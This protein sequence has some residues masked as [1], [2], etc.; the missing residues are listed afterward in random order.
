[1]ADETDPTVST[2]SPTDNATGVATNSNLVITFSEAVDVETGN[3]TIKKTS[4]NSTVEAIDVTGG[5]VTGTG[6]DTITINPTSDLDEQIEYYVLID[7]TAFADAASNFYAGIASTT[8]WSFTTADETDPTV[9]TLSPTDNATAVATNSDLVITFSEAMY[10]GTGNI[11]LYKATGDVD[12]LVQA[13]DVE[14]E[15]DGIGTNTITINPTSDLDS[16]TDY[17]VL[18]EADA[19][20][21]ESGNSF[22]GIADTTTWNFTSADI[23]NPAVSILSPADDA[24]A[25][26]V[27]SNFIITFSEAMYVGTGNI[28]LYKATGDVDVLVQ[29]FDVTTDITGTGDTILINPTSNLDGETDYYVQIDATAFED[30]SGN[31]FAGIADTITWNFTSADIANPTISGGLPS[32][33]QNADTTNVTMSVTTN[34]N[35]TCKYSSTSGIAFALMTAFTTTD[36]TSHS[37]SISGLNNGSSY[38]YYVLCQDSS[39]NE[40]TETTISFSVAS[41]IVSGGGGGGGGFSRPYSRTSEG[42]EVE[43][44]PPLPRAPEGGYVF[45][46]TP[47]P[48][49]NGFVTL[50]FEGGQD[51]TRIHISD[52]PSFSPVTYINYVTSTTWTFQSAGEKTLYAKFCNQYA[53]CGETIIAKVMYSPPSSPSSPPSP[54]SPQE[55]TEPNFIEK[56]TP[57]FI[58]KSPPEPKLEEPVVKETPTLSL[59]GDWK[60]LPN[61]LV[62][63][64]VL[65]PLPSDITKLTDKFPELEKVFARLGITKISDLEK[66]KNTSINLPLVDNKK[67]VP[68]EILVAEGDQGL[69]TLGSSIVLTSDGEVRQK[70]K[71]IAG[72][73]IIL[74]IK[75]ESPAERITGYLLF[76]R[77]LEKTAME[78]PLN[79]L[80]ASVLS[81]HTPVAQISSETPTIEQELLI[82]SFEYTDPDGDGIFTAEISAPVVDGE[83]EV[84]TVINYKDKEKGSKELRMITVIDPEGYVYKTNNGEETRISDANVSIFSVSNGTATLWD[85]EKYNQ[86]NPQITDNTGNYS[87]LVPPGKYYIT[88]EAK[89]YKSYNGDEFDV[90]EG[91]GVHLNILMTE[92]G[93]WFKVLVDWK[94]LI[95]IIFGIALLGNFIN[96]HRLKKQLSIK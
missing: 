3:I 14:T 36:A 70:I 72:K 4:D 49:T 15:I 38:S 42:G 46:I 21:D 60:L 62:Y 19:F 90:K 2:L 57:D 13:F 95:I 28:N 24:P 33:E 43:F 64:F 35:A 7:A 91:A 88:A 11:N 74:S 32:G 40:S 23:D 39:N 75:P 52:N 65:A 29:A 63:N 85:A 93:S 86:D 67:E 27:D 25:V 50:N 45:S 51:I 96:D 94:M 9:S 69:I 77:K 1:T 30:A 61:T 83:Y 48:T 79:S 53:R 59:E 89:G 20:D 12:V 66:L 5:L 80:V 10:A 54:P 71:T 55:N 6:T 8:A 16:E 78:T 56:I 81:A 31:S 73:P 26:A 44:S 18:I 82:Y 34:E 17:Y 37:T 87:F 76:K 68:P 92:D 22:A 47:N 84:L 58:K 41:V